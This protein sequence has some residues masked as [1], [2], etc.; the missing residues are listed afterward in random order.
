MCA[1]LQIILEKEM[2]KCLFF[3]IFKANKVSFVIRKS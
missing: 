3:I 2:T 1:K